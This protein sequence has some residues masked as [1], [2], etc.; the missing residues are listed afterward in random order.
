MKM[1]NIL[2][3]L[4]SASSSYL[5]PLCE[6]KHGEFATPGRDLCLW[7]LGSICIFPHTD[8][9]NVLQLIPTMELHLML[10]IVK[11]LL[12]DVEI[13][14]AN[15]PGC[16]LSID[17]WIHN[18]GIQWTAY[19]G[20]QFDGNNCSKILNSI[21]LLVRLVQEHGAVP[22]MPVVHT[23]HCFRGVKTSCLFKK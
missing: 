21:D 3:G 11:C 4:Q 15:I 10:G 17:A 23:L 19:H 8:N 1:A 5:C 2:L 16:N 9:T 22:V 12:D 20:G 13:Q 6:L 14:L 18:K 7:T